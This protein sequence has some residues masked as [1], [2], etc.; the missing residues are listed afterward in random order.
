M[1]DCFELARGSRGQWERLRAIC[2]AFA[3]AMDNVLDDQ[4]LLRRPIAREI[5]GEIEQLSQKISASVKALQNLED[6]LSKRSRDD[7]ALVE[8]VDAGGEVSP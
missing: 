4:N 1:S 7:L 2:E 5:R 8:T 3:D 6:S